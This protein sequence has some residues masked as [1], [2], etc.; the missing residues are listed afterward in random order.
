MVFG[1]R[2][3]P[4]R[5]PVTRPPLS[6]NDMTKRFHAGAIAGIAASLVCFTAPQSKPAA[7]SRDI[8]VASFASAGLSGM[9]AL[10]KLS[11]QTGLPM[12]IEWAG[13]S[14]G[15]AITQTWTRAKASTIARDIATV[16]FPKGGYTASIRHGVLEV[17]PARATRRNHSVADFVVTQFGVQHNTQPTAAKRLTDLVHCQ[18]FGHCGGT[19]IYSGEGGE[20]IPNRDYHNAPVVDILDDFVTAGRTM[21]IWIIVENSSHVVEGTQFWPTLMLPRFRELPLTEQPRW[22][23]LRW[24]EAP[25]GGGFGGAWACPRCWEPPRQIRH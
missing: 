20:V 13:T 22:L 12:G 4:S 23:V 16:S 21:R 8:T 3:G 25:T 15:P 17:R 1:P 24:R 11:A 18:I 7:E 9:D 2:T 5:L 14:A 6:H 10:A 19:E